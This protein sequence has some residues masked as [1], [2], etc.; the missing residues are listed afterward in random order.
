MIRSLASNVLLQVVSR[1]PGCRGTWETV[2][3]S[4][5]GVVA[6]SSCPWGQHIG[7]LTGLL[8]L[9]APAI[10][11]SLTPIARPYH[12]RLTHAI[13]QSS[14]TTSRD[15]H[16]AHT[17]NCL[18]LAGLVKVMSAFVKCLPDSFVVSPPTK[19]ILHTSVKHS[20]DE[21]I[22]PASIVFEGYKSLSERPVNIP[23][24]IRSC[25]EKSV[26][27]L[28]KKG[29]SLPAVVPHPHRALLAHYSSRI[30]GCMPHNTFTIPLHP[31]LRPGE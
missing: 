22:S 26:E 2:V 10:L 23:M 4:L 11:H 29:N 28:K 7:A 13:S 18:L 21:F 31:P 27:S 20:S 1:Q 17:T 12:A 19:N 30:T 24:S 15:I 25:W 16:D 5:G 8:I 3:T 6:S 9:G 14:I